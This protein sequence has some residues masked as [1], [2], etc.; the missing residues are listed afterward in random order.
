[1]IY[2][3]AIE[4]YLQK[5]FAKWAKDYGLDNPRKNY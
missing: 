4:K 5:H 3:N 1:M 2:Q